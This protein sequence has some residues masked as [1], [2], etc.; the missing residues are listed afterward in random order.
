MY[1]FGERL[2]SYYCCLDRL[3][4]VAKNV[5]ET[6]MNYDLEMHHVHAFFYFAFV[7]K[8]IFYGTL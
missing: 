5:L 2:I 1:K 7:V 4:A 3:L 8:K 6:E